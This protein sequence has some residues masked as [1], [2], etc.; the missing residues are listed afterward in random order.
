MV[1]VALRDL[2]TEPDFAIFMA[3]VRKAANHDGHLGARTLFQMA[4][5]QVGSDIAGR[6]VVNP[7]ISRTARRLNVR[8]KS[9]YA[10][11]RLPKTLQLRCRTYTSAIW[12]QPAR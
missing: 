7:E 4:S 2:A 12:K 6:S 3:A 5:H 1:P 8:N 9:R 11:S 10:F